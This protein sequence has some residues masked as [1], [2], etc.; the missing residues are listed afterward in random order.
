MVR[1]PLSKMFGRSLY[2]GWKKEKNYKSTEDYGTYLCIK[3]NH[4][5]HVLHLLFSEVK[6]ISGFFFFNNTCIPK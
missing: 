3:E 5:Q 2:A 6:V 1:D 4:E